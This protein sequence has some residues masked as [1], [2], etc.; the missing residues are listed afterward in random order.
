MKR[1][2]AQG[3]SARPGSNLSD[4][5]ADI[6]M[7]IALFYNDD[8]RCRYDRITLQQLPLE[9]HE[10]LREPDHCLGC[11]YK[12]RRTDSYCKHMIRSWNVLK[13]LPPEEFAKYACHCPD[14]C[15]SAV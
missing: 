2:E 12:Q 10:E 7:D 9:S 3:V 11:K 1:K 6:F 5:L 13:E 14:I 4:R 8:Y 15:S